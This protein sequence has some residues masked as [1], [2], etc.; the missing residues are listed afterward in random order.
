MTDRRVK[1]RR[2]SFS[3]VKKMKWKKK[4]RRGDRSSPQPFRP[5]VYNGGEK[6]KKKEEL[7]WI[8]HGR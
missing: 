4:I 3:S 7:N 5:I 1:N 8:K 2:A 6:R